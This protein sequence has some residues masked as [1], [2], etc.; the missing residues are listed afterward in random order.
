MMGKFTQRIRSVPVIVQSDTLGVAP[1]PPSKLWSA[2]GLNAGSASPP[3]CQRARNV[4]TWSIMMYGFVSNRLQEYLNP[5]IFDS[6][7]GE[8]R[9]IL[10]K[11]YC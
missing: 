4:K 8:D 9:E 3:H 2:K 6:S 5:V 11:Y 1:S 7:T 10:G